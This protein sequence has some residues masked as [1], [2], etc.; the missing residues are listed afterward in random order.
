LSKK[1][2][3]TGHCL[4]CGATLQGPYCH[5]CGQEATNHPDS[6]W[7]LIQHF[8]EDI[9]HYDGKLWQT[10]K[11][12]LTRP[13]FLT[14]QY[15][16]GKR[17]GYL[18][19]VRL[20]IFLN[21]I[22][23]FLL[24]SLPSMQADKPQ[25]Q[26]IHIGDVNVQPLPQQLQATDSAV[27]HDVLATKHIQ[28]KSAIGYN[29]LA[30]YDSAQNARPL[31][32]RDGFVKRRI[33]MSWINTMQAIKKDPGHAEEKVNEVFLHHAPKLTFLF[34]IIC[35][36]SLYVLYY[37]QHL[38][39]VSHALFAI[40]LA[41]TFLLLCILMLVAGYLPG[42]DYI[43]WAIFLFGNYYFFRAL[44][45]VYGQRWLKTSIKF[46]LINFCLVLGMAAGLILNALFTLMSVNG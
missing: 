44:R 43:L 42:S 36:L 12:L 11:P 40:H 18:N 46:M 3:I 22:F 31:S 23:F 16:Q 20:F 28:V 2:H 38:Y 37:R 19:P 29:T 10:V 21:F 25:K 15:L 35:S 13:G 6:I 39:M 14:Q 27:N 41:C 45:V 17:A 26:A 32:Q 34:I 30:E 24:L 4:N 9:T 5:C 7:H 8:F 1:R 33:T